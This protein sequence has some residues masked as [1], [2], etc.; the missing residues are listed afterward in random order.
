MPRRKLTAFHRNKEV[1]VTIGKPTGGTRE[2]GET[3][4]ST[5]YDKTTGVDTGF[6]KRTS[7]WTQQEYGRRDIDMFFAAF[8]PDV[9]IDMGY[10]L[11]VTSSD[12]EPD[13]SVGDHFIVEG[14]YNRKGR[15][16]AVDL[17]YNEN[18]TDQ[19]ELGS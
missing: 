2:S 17:R 9:D 18:M 8:D 15:A 7:S 19:D 11:K 13:P 5:T 14:V 4:L 6:V 16:I 1:T 10:V 12:Q 3:H